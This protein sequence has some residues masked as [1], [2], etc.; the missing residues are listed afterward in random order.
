MASVPS[1][2][3]RLLPI[4][5]TIRVSAPVFNHTVWEYPVVLQERKGGSEVLV[6]SPP[7]VRVFGVVLN[8]APF[9]CH[10]LPGWI[11]KSEALPEYKRG[12]GSAVSSKCKR[13]IIKCLQILSSLPSHNLL[14]CFHNIYHFKISTEILDHSYEFAQ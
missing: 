1:A 11:K 7:V 14:A 5:F 6:T 4:L 3:G 10:R 8:A 9:H 13:E 12:A 2:V